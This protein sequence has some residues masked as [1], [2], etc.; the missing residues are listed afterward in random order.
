MNQG[1]NSNKIVPNRIDT[2]EINFNLLLD[3]LNKMIPNV[4][5]NTIVNPD[6]IANTIATSK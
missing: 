1:I 2:I 5:V 3:S 4:V 6:H